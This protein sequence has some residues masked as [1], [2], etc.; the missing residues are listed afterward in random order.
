[1]LQRVWCACGTFFLLLLLLLLL[2]HTSIPPSQSLDP[3]LPSPNTPSFHL[4]HDVFVAGDGVEISHVVLR[5]SA[6]AEVSLLVDERFLTHGIVRSGSLIDLRATFSLFKGSPGRSPEWWMSH[7]LTSYPPL[8]AVERERGEKEAGSGYVFGM[9]PTNFGWQ[10]GAFLGHGPTLL[11]LLHDAP[12][13]SSLPLSGIEWTRESGWQSAQRSA[14]NIG[15]QVRLIYT[16]FLSPSFSLP[17]FLSLS[18]SLS[19]LVKYFVMGVR[20]GRAPYSW[21]CHS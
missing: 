19:L 13:L 9:C 8:V 21:K 17:H 15:T 1:M 6:A 18:L 3:P 5:V 4:A 12:S 11:S 2:L 14:E 20:C 16:L 7:Y 10:H